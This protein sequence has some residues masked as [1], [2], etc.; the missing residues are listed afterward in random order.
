MRVLSDDDQ[1]FEMAIALSLA[2]SDGG[3][4]SALAQI[5]QQTA[6][7]SPGTRAAHAQDEAPSL[8]TK[9]CPP[10]Q[11]LPQS[12]SPTS[13]SLPAQET[14]TTAPA[15]SQ[16]PSTQEDVSAVDLL[17]LSAPAPAAANAPTSLSLP[18]QET[19]TTAPALSLPPSSHTRTQEDMS[20][21]DLLGLSAPA[22][23]AVNAGQVSPNRTKNTPHTST[24]EDVSVEDLLGLSAPA[25]VNARQVYAAPA[26]V[27]PVEAVAPDDAT[28]ATNA[29]T[30]P[31][32]QVR[33]I[34]LIMCSCPSLMH[35]A[36]GVLNT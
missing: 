22:P 3:G 10:P 21:E 24:Q 15:L 27:L 1:E 8:A 17:G 26:E 4:A 33:H 32:A 23:A 29:P 31:L 19:P 14:P 12:I 16:S 28:S 13:F 35:R 5:E 36:Q 2:S 6:A 9:G 25:A 7:I 18:A 20:A 11:I 34:W 30:P